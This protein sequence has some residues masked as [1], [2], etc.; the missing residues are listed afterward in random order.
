MPIIPCSST[1]VRLLCA[2]LLASLLIATIV[3]TA[4]GAGRSSDHR[5]QENVD[6]NILEC[7]AA[8]HQALEKHDLKEA[9]RAFSSC[10]EKYPGVAITHYWLG[11]GHF[12]DRE[13]Q[14]AIEEFNE[15]VRLD[16][17]NAYAAAMLGRIY[18]L[19]Q[20]QLP[21]AQEQLERALAINSELEDARFDL[22][23]VYAQQ[24]HLVQAF[25]EFGIIFSGEAKYGLYHTELAK[26]LIAAD[27]MQDA[28]KELKRALALAPDF[29]PAKQL[30]ENLEKQGSTTPP[31]P[32]SPP[33]KSATPPA[34]RPLPSLL[35]FSTIYSNAHSTKY[36][37]LR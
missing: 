32:I 30:L 3:G 2:T 33:E 13:N 17:E 7:L 25:R 28:E 8:G 14:K 1:C 12:F 22:A 29:G 27:R 23:R 24:G 9:A 18:S 37:N 5:T 10:V 36:N 20:N 19:A 26:I 16:P 31:M 35:S 6:P 4:V 11:M 15:V 21:M 34:D